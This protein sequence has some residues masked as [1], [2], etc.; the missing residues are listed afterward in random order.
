MLD[1]HCVKSGA[2][3]LTVG[4][5]TP[6]TENPQIS[7]RSF[8]VSKST[9][10]KSTACENDETVE[11]RYVGFAGFRPVST[12]TGRRRR[13]VAEPP[14]EWRG[15]RAR[16]TWGRG[17]APAGSRAAAS[18][19]WLATTSPSPPATTSAAPSGAAPCAPT[20]P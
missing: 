6:P 19:S 18:T 5:L 11:F 2:F 4:A 15:L 10:A 1:E 16:R 7:S 17:A 3:L 8:P 9:S 13:R 14:A 12:S 20:T